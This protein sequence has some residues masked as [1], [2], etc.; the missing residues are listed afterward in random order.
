MASDL[1]HSRDHGY[2][3]HL[4]VS[5][6]YIYRESLSFISYAYVQL[7]TEFTINIC[8][9]C[10]IN[11]SFEFTITIS[12]D[13]TKLISLS[14][15]KCVIFLMSISVDSTIT[16][17]DAHVFIICHMQLN[18]KTLLISQCSL[19]QIHPHLPIPSI[20]HLVE[21]TIIFH[22]NWNPQSPCSFLLSQV[23]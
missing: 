4:S 18:C 7:S 16:N 5:Q 15:P 9:K 1:I 17:P 23:L 12:I 14:L 3:F 8:H 2:Y 19:S 20:T 22:Q 10:N 13:W 21:I 11:F 6:I